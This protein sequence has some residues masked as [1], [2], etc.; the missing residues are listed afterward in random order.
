MADAFTS[1]IPALTFPAGGNSINAF[2][3]NGVNRNIDMM[4]FKS[5]TNWPRANDEYNRERWMHSDFKD[6]AYSLNYK[7]FDNIANTRGLK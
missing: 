6:I 5:E 1:G 2:D 7:L 4:R 3:Q